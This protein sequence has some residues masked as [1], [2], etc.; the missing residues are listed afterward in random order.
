MENNQPKILFSDYFGISKKAL[1]DYGAFD[2]SLVADLPLF[3]DPFLLFNSKKSEYQ[4]LHEGIITYLR[5]LR[6]KS[7]SQPINKGLLSAWYRF[8]EVE[9]NWFGFSVEGNKGSALGNDFARALNE[10]FARI[11]NDYGQEKVT[12]S[13]HLEK[14]CLIKDG[15]G[16]DNISDF[17]TNLI[18]DYLLQYTQVFAQKHLDPKLCRNFRVPRARFNYDTQSWEE[19]GYYL[20]SFQGDF[21]ILTPKDMLTKDET[22]INKDDLVDEFASIPYAISNEELRAKV[23]NYF[24]SVLPEE[25]KRKDE[26]EAAIKTILEFPELIDYY[27]KRKE[28]NGDR[29]TSISEQKVA[30]SETVYTE[31]FKALALLLGEKTDFYKTS[32]DSYQEA[33]QRVQYLKSVIENNDGYR[34]FYVNGEPIRREEDLKIAYRL[35]WY[36]STFDFNTEVNNGRGPVDVKVSKGSADKS[37]VELKLATN[38]QLERNLQ[39]QVGVYE[40]ANDTD[41]NI[42]VI[43]YFTLKELKRV[44]DILKRLGLTDAENIVLIDARKDNKPSASKA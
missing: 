38:T 27:I 35:T 13:S 22:W 6:D 11:F 41:K 42:K 25:P 30:F 43:I 14:L 20:P 28:D 10:N 39:N 7:T 24:Q 19:D 3:I 5:F 18:K 26:K 36:G 21:V 8:K 16:K 34:Y 2:I 1:E 29:A 15:V 37:L 23:N 31:Q 9:Q 33:M 40:K 32:P 44:Q 17:T 12:R 4:Q